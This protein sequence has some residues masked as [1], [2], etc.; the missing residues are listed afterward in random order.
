MNG[1]KHV[2]GPL[3]LSQLHLSVKAMAQTHKSM[4]APEAARSQGLRNRRELVW[5]QRPHKWRDEARKM[6]CGRSTRALKGKV[7]CL[8]FVVRNEKSLKILH[9]KR[10]PWGLSGPVCCLL[11][12]RHTAPY[13]TNPAVPGQPQGLALNDMQRR[14]IEI[15]LVL[16]FIVCH[17][18]P[19]NL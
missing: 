17:F 19:V 12:G 18:A 6:G 10:R 14:F 3:R 9:R 13:G 15:Y 8:D 1:L 4:A 16:C 5:P 2:C 7:R 11:H